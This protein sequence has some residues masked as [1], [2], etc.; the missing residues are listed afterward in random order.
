MI[1]CYSEL[2]IKLSIK[3]L[4]HLGHLGHLKRWSK[5]WSTYL[6]DNNKVT[7]MMV[8]MAKKIFINEFLWLVLTSKKHTQT[9]NKIK[10]LFLEKFQ[11]VPWIYNPFLSYCNSLLLNKL[12]GIE[13]E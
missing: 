12:E 6:I 3:K 13:N 7:I 9:Q 10:A 8:K 4:G 11:I 5:R 1:V 2:I